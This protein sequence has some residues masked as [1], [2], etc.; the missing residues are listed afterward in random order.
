MFLVLCN[1]IE[2]TVFVNILTNHTALVLFTRLNSIQQ[3]YGQLRLLIDADK[4][5]R[6]YQNI[7]R[8]KIGRRLTYKD[9]K[10]Y[11]AIPAGK[12]TVLL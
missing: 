1:T 9:N 10:C 7:A 5:D 11:G 2:M 12:E 6:G 3:Q 4:G 8:G